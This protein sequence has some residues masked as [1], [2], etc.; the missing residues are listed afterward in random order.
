M[1]KQDGV[2]LLRYLGF[3]TS[4][5]GEDSG[6]KTVSV[7][8]RIASFHL[9]TDD[10]LSP[11]DQNTLAILL[12]ILGSSLSPSFFH[13]HLIDF[14]TPTCTNSIKNIFVVFLLEHLLDQ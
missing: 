10:V 3:F 13:S 8:V 9:I 1:H 4:K 6:S 5:S 11:R 12:P 14:Y 7:Y 2:L